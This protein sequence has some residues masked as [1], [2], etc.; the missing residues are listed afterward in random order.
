[1]PSEILKDSIRAEIDDSVGDPVSL[2]SLTSDTAALLLL[3]L[4]ELIV[5]LHSNGTPEIKSAIESTLNGKLLPL[6]QDFISKV[7]DGSVVLP[8]LVKGV[9]QTITEIE[10]ASTKVSQILVDNYY[11]PTNV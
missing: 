8:I 7:N 3:G 1:M 10:I 6:S 2:T 11:D 9:E 4:T 5:A